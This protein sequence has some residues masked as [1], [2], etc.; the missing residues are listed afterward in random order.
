MEKKIC[1][2]DAPRNLVLSRCMGKGSASH[3]GKKMEDMKLAPLAK[4][5]KSEKKTRLSL[6]R[7]REILKKAFLRKKRKG[8]TIG[9]GKREEKGE[10]LTFKKKE[11]TVGT[12]H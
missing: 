11:L 2:G 6:A 3:Q 1:W 9:G 12:S 8:N 10:V 7:K 4:S 5:R